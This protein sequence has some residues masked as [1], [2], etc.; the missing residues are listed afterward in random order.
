MPRSQPEMSETFGLLQF[1]FKRPLFDKHAHVLEPRPV[2]H[3]LR[4]SYMDYQSY[5][6]QGQAFRWRQLDIMVEFI[7]GW[8][9]GTCV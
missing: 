1:G 7:D 8:R 5:A 9:Q 3:R 4:T 6:M 2:T